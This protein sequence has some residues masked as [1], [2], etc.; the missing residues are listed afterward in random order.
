MG[1]VL[2]HANKAWVWNISIRVCLQKGE[3]FKAN[4]MSIIKTMYMLCYKLY[5]CWTLC[6]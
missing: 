2:T 4:Q 6:E 5:I 3:K 1:N